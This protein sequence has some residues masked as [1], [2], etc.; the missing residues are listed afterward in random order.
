MYLPRLCLCDSSIIGYLDA[1]EMKV[2]DQR[3]RCLV[4]MLFVTVEEDSRL[5]LMPKPGAT[6]PVEVRERPE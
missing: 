4:V 3:Q 5:C 1:K 6:E 2:K